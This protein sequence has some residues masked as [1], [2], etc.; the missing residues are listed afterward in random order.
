MLK[1]E[2]KKDDKPPTPD[3]A[4]WTAR[5]TT[6]PGI[7]SESLGEKLWS[8]QILKVGAFCPY[9]THYGSLCKKAS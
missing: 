4:T 7:I 9:Y 2:N 3:A 1:N 6:V 8:K 5:S